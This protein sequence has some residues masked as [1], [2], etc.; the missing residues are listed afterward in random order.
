M[1]ATNAN[2]RF[3]Q[4]IRIGRSSAVSR[5]TRI[6]LSVLGSLLLAATGF[7]SAEIFKVPDDYP[8]IGAAITAASAGD[9]IWVAEGTYRQTIRL[10]PNLRLMGGYRR[11][12]AA[13]NWTLWQTVIDA[14]GFPGPAV[15]G[16]DAATLDGF[17]IRNAQS[18]LGGGIYLRDGGM[19]IIHNTIEDNR[20]SA[21]GGAICVCG[22]SAG[23]SRTEIRDNR[24][25]RNIANDRPFAPGSHVIEDVEDS[26]SGGG[27]LVWNSATPVRIQDNTIE[28]NRAANGGGI[29]V[30]GSL[31]VIEGNQISFNEARGGNGGGIVM[32]PMTRNSSVQ[33]NRVF[34]NDADADGGGILVIGAGL[35]AGNEIY[36][37]TSGISGGRPGGGLSANSDGVMEV[38]NN[39]IFNNSNAGADLGDGLS[40][41]ATNDGRIQ[42]V[43]NTIANNPSHSGGNGVYLG[44]MQ[45]DASICIFQNNI[46]WGYSDSL[47]QSDDALCEIHYNLLQ[48]EELAGVNHN[49][50]ADPHFVSATDVHIA[51]ASPARNAGTD[52]FISS[53]A[54][55][56]RAPEDDIDGDDRT[57]TRPVDIGA[58]EVVG[59]TSEATIPSWF[60]AL[61][62]ILPTLWLLWWQREE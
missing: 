49:I 30:K 39:F 8:T 58:D 3:F 11:D 7:A 12:F 18:A 59:I 13:R 23:R 25:R 48:G 31:V 6:A 55:R 4:K 41:S 15:T 20:S 45:P 42:V 27:I 52:E 50:D 22:V 62:I 36:A 5:G 28:N 9:D 24:I 32:S 14:D 37:N 34:N 56:L 26:V 57:V 1:A 60:V 54:L 40:L 53:L 43:N 16:A 10:K 19:T 38:I 21:G 35:V 33:G 2:I 44:Y 17:V 29:S 61:L 46:V 47:R 51:T